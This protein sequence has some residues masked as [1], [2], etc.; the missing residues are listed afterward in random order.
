MK[1]DFFKE[2]RK[3]L[4]EI[5]PDNSICILFSGKPVQKSADETYPFTPNRN[6]YYLTGISQENCILILSRTNK[7]N[8]EYLWVEPNNPAL[9]R[10]VGEKITPEEASKASGITVVK[11]MD[12]FEE[13]LH[14][15]LSALPY[16][17]VFID[18]ERRSYKD[19]V[20]FTQYFAQSIAQK[21]PYIRIQNAYSMIC[22]LRLVKT[23]GE[24]EKIR[25]AIDITHR[26]LT[27]I[28]NHC[29]PGLKEYELEAH[30]DFELKASGITD[31]AFRTI[32]AGG[33]N[34]SILHYNDNK[35]ELTD[36]DLVLLDL[37]AQFEFY[38]ADIT[39]TLPVNGK[40]SPR[41]KELYQMVL[42]T[43]LEVIEK[44]KPGVPF[45]SLND[46]CKGKLCQCATKNGLIKDDSQLGEYYF[47]GVSH[48][49]GLD[50]HDVGKSEELRPGMVIT[51]EPGLY[52]REER[53]GIRIEDDILVTES[54]HENLSKK[55]PKTIKE[56][57]HW[58]EK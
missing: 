23:P 10:W 42:D 39:R 18:L 22:N 14:Q 15:E 40:F 57:E 56:V 13:T 27:R 25:K 7:K 46:C 43:Q 48:F 36:G 4:L 12:T 20:S 21:Y 33:I 58:M 28:A 32:A 55:I 24:V 19:V 5:L 45:A 53:L 16:P 49:L 34:A 54:G 29:A 30:F 2:N 26:G 6:F 47:H 50:T 41:Q 1:M 37:G 31:H 8:K 52:L 51:V 44:I 3:R 11:L 17:E 9:A 38:N 35:W